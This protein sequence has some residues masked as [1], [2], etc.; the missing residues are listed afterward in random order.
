MYQN[1]LINSL[2]NCL[3]GSYGKICEGEGVTWSC[4]C[5]YAS[6]ILRLIRGV[7]CIFVSIMK[8]NTNLNE[9]IG[10]YPTLVVLSLKENCSRLDKI[11]LL[12]ISKM[13]QVC[14][15]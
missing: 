6:W 3:I 8:I 10:K 15:L 4:N 1:L 13:D 11:V 5:K 9:C 2:K 12:F 7:S 14:T